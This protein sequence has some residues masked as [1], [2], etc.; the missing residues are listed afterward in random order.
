M[1]AIVV[2]PV[3]ILVF[4]SLLYVRDQA[5]RKQAAEMHAR[6][7]AWLY[8]ANNCEEIPAG[9]DDVLTSN[10]GVSEDEVSSALGD[11]ADRLTE[12]GG[13]V[14]SVVEPLIMPALQAAFGRSL[15]A[16]TSRD[17]ARPGIYGGG[18]KTVTGRYHLVCN[19]KH[20][21]PEDVVEDAWRLIRPW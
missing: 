21:D 17:V 13:V 16:T 3:F 15:D 10:D 20:K 19:L 1:E 12:G 9:C 4:I 11:A 14:E 8:S 18:M 6:S 2:L 7:C 5:V